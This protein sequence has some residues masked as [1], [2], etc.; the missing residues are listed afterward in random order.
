MASKDFNWYAMAPGQSADDFDGSG[1][2]LSGGATIVQTQRADGRTGSV[3]NLPNKAKAVSPLMCV[4]SDYE[5]ARAQIRSLTAYSTGG[6]TVAAA[7]KGTTSWNNPKIGNFGGN[8]TAWKTSGTADLNPAAASGWQLVQLTLTSATS[9]KGYQVYDL[10]AR[11]STK[12]ALSYSDTSGCSQHPLSQPF[13]AASDGH[14]YAMAPGQST[15]SFGGSGWTL[16]GG[17]TVA[18]ARLADGALGSVLDLPGGSR[19]VSP[20]MCVSSDYELARAQIRRLV[21]GSGGVTLAAE[22]QGTTSWNNPKTSNLGGNDTAW[23][24]SSTAGLQ[25]AGESG[26]QLMRITLTNTSSAAEY[27]L[28]NLAAQASDTLALAS[29]DTSACVPPELSQPFLWAADARWY[30]P[31][32]GVSAAGFDGTGWTLTG[33]ASI[34]QA[35]LPNGSI[36]PVLDLPPGSRAVAPVMCVTV[37]YP[38]ARAH[39]RQVAGDGSVQMYVSYKGTTSWNN[40]EKSADVRGPKNAWGLS[41]DAKI[42]PGKEPGWQL[43]QIELAPRDS[44][45]S[46][47]YDFQVD[48]RMR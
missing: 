17:A 5:V 15:D 27:Q 47:V 26:W 3:L 4:S 7:V 9:G 48:P 22:I 1:W 8:D 24:A 31:A 29:V 46:Q 38:L 33:G 12:L 25:P 16:S 42:N 10:G 35:P 2:T 36:G 37:D 21:A 11:A 34:V 23:V 18:Q 40:P 41:G 20:L 44:N 28:Y 30:T 45:H 19:A 14:W 6:V 39:L 43:V 32:P 13:L